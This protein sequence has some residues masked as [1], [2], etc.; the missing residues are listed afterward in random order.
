M[1][2][3]E[4]HFGHIPE[5]GFIEDKWID[6]VLIIWDVQL[7]ILQP[8]KRCIMT[9]TRRTSRFA[10]RS[11]SALRTLVKQ[12]N[13]AI[14]A[15]TRESSKQELFE[16]GDVVTIN[17]YIVSLKRGVFHEIT[18]LSEDKLLRYLKIFPLLILV[19]LIFHNYY[20]RKLCDKTNP[21]IIV[22]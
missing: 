6:K 20:H 9:T 5:E 13:P 2:L 8:T 18:R 3:T 16:L 21:A 12:N 15:C 22:V 14:S 17:N 11:G 1:F 10:I 4:N 19:L 7:K